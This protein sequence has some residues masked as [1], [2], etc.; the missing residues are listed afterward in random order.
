MLRTCNVLLLTY[1]AAQ[2]AF[3]QDSAPQSQGSLE[4]R[5]VVEKVTEVVDEAGNVKTEIVPVETALPGDEVVYTVTF[6]NVGDQTA[7]HILITNPIPPEM[8]YVED[9]ATGPGTDIRYSA[10]GGQTYAKPEE[11]QVPDDAGGERTAAADEYTHIRWAL[12][13]PL[14]A[15]SQGFARFR[16]V[17]R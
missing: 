1:F 4:L 9:S 7:D 3:A 6:K 5:T 13:N 11:I 8:S 12:N 16:A 10:D 14:D 15:G 17:V 2:L